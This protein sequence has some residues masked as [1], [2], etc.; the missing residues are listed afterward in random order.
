MLKVGALVER[1]HGCVPHPVA[2]VNLS[3]SLQLT[4]DGHRR[5][6]G[7]S[8]RRLAAVDR[9]PQWPTDIASSPGHTARPEHTGREQ[10]A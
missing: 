8:T 5:D 3:A 4:G 7:F 10:D 6:H 1:P 9:F 2:N